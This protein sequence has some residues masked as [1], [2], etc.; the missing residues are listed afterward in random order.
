V[1]TTDDRTL[2]VDVVTDVS[3]YDVVDGRGQVSRRE[4]ARPG[5]TSRLVLVATSQGWR[6]QDAR[7]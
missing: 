1:R 3:A 7:A 6:V 4:A 2:V 5:T